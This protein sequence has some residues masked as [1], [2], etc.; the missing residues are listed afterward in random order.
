LL[1]RKLEMTG[2]LGVLA[3]IDKVRFRGTVV[4]GDQLRLEVEILRL[5]RNRAQVKAQAK[6]GRRIASEA[7]L[8][9]AMIEP[10]S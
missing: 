10:A 9:F 1:Q 4:P 3:S 6:V 8:S 5:Q 7:M 2:M